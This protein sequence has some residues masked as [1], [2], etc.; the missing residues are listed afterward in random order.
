MIKSKQFMLKNLV[1]PE[2]VMGNLLGK[3]ICVKFKV[4]RY[5]HKNSCHGGDKEIR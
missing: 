4:S 1:F 2:D 5:V 3:G